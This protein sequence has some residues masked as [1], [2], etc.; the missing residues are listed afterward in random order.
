[1]DVFDG[2]VVDRYTAPSRVPVSMRFHPGFIAGDFVACVVTDFSA[3][4]PSIA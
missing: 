3:T 2:M 4:R 1:M